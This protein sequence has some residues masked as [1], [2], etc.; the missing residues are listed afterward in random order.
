MSKKFFLATIMMMALPFF[1]SQLNAAPLPLEYG[2]TDPTE[3]QEGPHRN[4]VTVPLVDIEDYTLTFS[5]P[6]F[7]WTLVLINENDE[8]AYTTIVTSDTLVLP[9]TLSGEYQLR[10]IPND[11][12]IYFYGYVMF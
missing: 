4:P 12:N 8:V 2:Y 10:L 6:C 1:S 7:G 5:T 3:D 9:S 11:G